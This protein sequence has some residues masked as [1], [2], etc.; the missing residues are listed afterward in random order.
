MTPNKGRDSTIDRIQ[1]DFK[2]FD[3]YMKVTDQVG[4][5]FKLHSLQFC[6]LQVTPETTES[7]FNVRSR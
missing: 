3:N 4:K 2:L 1:N 5:D 6:L 7:S